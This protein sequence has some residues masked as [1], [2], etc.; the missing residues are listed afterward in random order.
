MIN[1]QALLV[2]FS[3]GVSSLNPIEATT[4]QAEDSPFRTL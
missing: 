4:I 1:M 3:V 2:L